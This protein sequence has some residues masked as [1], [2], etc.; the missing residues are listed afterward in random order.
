M[1]L[2]QSDVAAAVTRRNMTPYALT[3]ELEPGVNYREHGVSGY[4]Y[5][6]KSKTLS[7]L[8]G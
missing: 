1:L 4:G 5:S 3:Y 6:F 7:A 2:V 8:K